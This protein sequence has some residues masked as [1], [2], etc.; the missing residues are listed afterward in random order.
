[1]TANHPAHL[2]ARAAAALLAAAGLT[3]CSPA[4]PYSPQPTRPQPTSAADAPDPAPERGGTI[5]A[6]DQAAQLTLA[7]AAAQPTPQAALARYA[8]LAVNWNWQDLAGLQ[9]RLAALSL[10]PARAQ[11][12]QAAAHAATDTT[13]RQQ[14]IRNSGRA[15]AIA[16]GQGQAAGRWVIVTRERTTGQGAYAGLPPTLH[17]TYAQLTRTPTGWVISQWQPQT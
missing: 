6:A 1:M 4:R 9:R 3:G 17:V 10:G 8:R 7:P 11:A 12:L 14:H 5:P 13:L 15:V 2:A 16:Q